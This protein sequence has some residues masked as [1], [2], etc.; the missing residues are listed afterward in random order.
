MR[1]AILCN[2]LNNISTIKFL[3][4]LI[5]LLDRFSSKI[6]LFKDDYPLLNSKV[7]TVDATGDTKK[8]LY[9]TN[10][11]IT[12]Y[13]GILIMQ[14][15]YSYY[16]LVNRKNV[17]VFIGLPVVMVLPYIII[18]IINK[19]FILYEAQDVIHDTRFRIL[20]KINYAIKKF[21]RDSTL[22]LC[23]III[24]EG[25]DIIST[26]RIE[27]LY[28]KIYVCPQFV[29]ISYYCQNKPYESRL[30]SV[31]F[32]ASLEDRKGIVEFLDACE[33]L[34]NNKH[35]F[36]TTIIGNG[37]YKKYLYSW[38]SR[39]SLEDYVNYYDFVDDCSLL[40]I[41]NN[42]KFIILPSRA[43]G[44]PNIILESMACGTIPIVTK[45]GA[46]SNL[47]VN[48][49]NGFLIG[50]VSPA[51]IA[52]RINFALNHPNLQDLSNNAIKTILVKYSFDES[53]KNYKILFD[54]LF[55]I[56]H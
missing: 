28:S 52:E 27:K 1:I 43:E 36:T 22:H 18:K 26:N 10:N 12:R 44:L 40:E 48:G 49:Y 31:A 21:L 41:L 7:V 20:E 42:S 4:K 13:L 50:S 9:H 8:F 46:I 45:C 14:I 2:P 53:I 51:S 19:K 33:I 17:D 29:D 47:I 15:K 35:N 23:D 38:I 34:Y 39:N 24:V 3:N 30:P 54:N 55:F 56:K 25:Y 6:I 5:K 11:I 37:P 16:I 32:I